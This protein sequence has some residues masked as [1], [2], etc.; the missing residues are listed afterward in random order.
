LAAP[1]SSKTCETP[2]FDVSAPSDLPVLQSERF[3]L[4]INMRTANA[5][6]LTIPNTMQLLADE[7]IRAPHRFHNLVC[8]PAQLG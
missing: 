8:G 5:L 2:E 7:V 3:E 6:G 4:V 1:A